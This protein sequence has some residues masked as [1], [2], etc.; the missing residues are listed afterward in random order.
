MV[1]PHR[2]WCRD[3]V[4]AGLLPHAGGA[5]GRYSSHRVIDPDAID[6]VVRKYAGGLDLDRRHS[7]HSMRATFCRAARDCDRAGEG[8]AVAPAVFRSSA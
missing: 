6:S 7:V 4:G 5:I 1:G 8:R 3:R 2:H